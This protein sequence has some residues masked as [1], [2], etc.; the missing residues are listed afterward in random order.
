[1]GPQT[2]TQASTVPSMLHWSTG[3]PRQFRAFIGL[4]LPHVDAALR[5]L[6][7]G[8]ALPWRGRLGP[9]LLG[10]GRSLDDP[11]FD[12]VFAELNCRRSVVLVHPVGVVEDPTATI[13][14]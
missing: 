14:A 2:E 12:P 7:R 5:K 10:P 3:H 9:G 4:P 8:L 1:M 11:A 13:S 6:E